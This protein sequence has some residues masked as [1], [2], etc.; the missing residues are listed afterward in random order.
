MRMG[1]AGERGALSSN[2]MRK[3][4]RH[5][6][7]SAPSN[8]STYHPRCSLVME[9]GQLDRDAACVESTCMPIS[10]NESHSQEALFGQTLRSLTICLVSRSYFIHRLLQ[11]IH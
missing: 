6:S 1:A 10:S 5:E 7:Y 4:S 8:R 3:L 2:A 11:R 9:M